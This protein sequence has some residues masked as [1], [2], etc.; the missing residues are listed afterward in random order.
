VVAK[1]VPVEL[2]KC[3]NIPPYGGEM[4]RKAYTEPPWLALGVSR[5]TWYRLGKPQTKPRRETQAQIA[6]QFDV[7][8]RGL[9]RTGRILRDAPD[10]VEQV[11]AGTLSV[12]T[13]ERLVIERQEAAALAYFRAELAKR[14][15]GEP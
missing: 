4:R 13:A 5:A 3:L 9:Q 6:R 11:E 10:L 15:Q 8:L 2:A 12:G 1:V 14:V 7:S